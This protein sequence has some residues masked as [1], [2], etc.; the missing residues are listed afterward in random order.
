ML[1]ALL[2][3][4]VLSAASPDDKAILGFSDSQAAEQRSLEER[5]DAQI[6]ADNL[7]DWMKRLTARP[8]H[9]G[10]PYGKENA[11]FIAAQFK[12]WGY[13]TRIEEF[14]V[15]FPTPKSRL[16]EMV[17]P[18]PFKASLAEPALKE[19]ATSGQ[20]D[21]QLPV[22]N[23]YSTDGDVTGDLVYVNF[24]VPKDYDELERRGIDVKGKIVIAR[25]YGSWRGIKPKVAAEHGAIG[26]IIYS[27]PHE[28]GFFQGD[29]YPKGSFRN[30]RGAQRGSVADMPLYPGDP[31]TPGVGAT[32]DAKRLPIKDAPTLTKIPVL[33]ISYEDALPLL[34]AIGGPVAPESWR[35]ALPTTY[36]IGPGP[37]KVRLKL[38]F[39][40][41]LVPCF[42]VIA[43]MAGSERPNQWVLRGNHHDAWVNG[44]DDPISGLVAVMEEAR[45]FSELAK[46][47]WKPRRSI[48]FCAWD[49]EEPGLLGSTEWVEAHAAEL[50]EHAVAYVNS[51]NNGRGF[52]R[53][54]GSHSLERLVNQAARDVIDPQKKIPIA[55]RLRA[56]RL[57]RGSAEE[58]KDARDRAELRIG[59]LGSGSD[60][61]A[62]LD[63]LGIASLD[64][65]F[66][67]EDS[68]GSY[69]SIYDSFDH[70]T[71]F[72]DPGFHYGVALAQT[73]GRI[74][75][76]LANAATLP[77]EFGPS[78]D[79]ISGYAREV[80]KL[81]DDLREETEKT[82]RLIREGRY[83][84]AADPTETFVAPKPKTPVPHLNFAPLQNAVARLRQSAQD[85]EHARRGLDLSGKGAAE[86]DVVLFRTERALTGDGLPRRPWFKHL[87]YAPGFYTGY[88]VKTLPGIRE[89]I[90]E[91]T[92][93]EAGAQTEATAR[94]IER[95]AAEIE[96][97]TALLKAAAKN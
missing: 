74:V 45:A 2:A 41:K 65:R 39:D 69:H 30:A 27:D 53:A 46:T 84:A 83:E 80:A 51:D 54:Q 81:T 40:W 19:D 16:L 47:G 13:D 85:H 1:P 20:S 12:S 68:G 75:L 59:A 9:V 82:N 24:G 70:Y 3:A 44:A 49:G 89:A 35:G 60:Y 48:V 62:F 72:G 33:P 8:H 14:K 32:E 18:T 91:R 90:E 37:A 26:C 88:G 25:Y 86:V 76:R 57:T 38:E 63:H 64:V 34:Q 23:A 42:N 7:R 22:Y 93:D 17:E 58:Q 43:R 71:R 97:A 5:F 52:L 73:A 78:A 77:F 96:K 50:K 21:E 66:G 11:E 55:E 61:T 6:R 4:A 15:L 10:S 94:A 67:G 36:H 28:D 87:I 31:L 92:W 95:Y 29:V 56:L 79:A